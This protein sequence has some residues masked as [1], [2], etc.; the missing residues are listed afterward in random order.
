MLL[1]LAEIS[2][3]TSSTGDR[4]SPRP[5][6]P[7]PVIIHQRPGLPLVGFQTLPDHFLT[8]VIADYQLGAVKIANS[9]D[10]GRLEMD[11]INPSAG[12]TRT[13]SGK[14]EQQLIIVHRQQD[15]NRR[16]TAARNA[17]LSKNSFSRNA[18]SHPAWAAVRGNP[19]RIKPRPQS[20]WS[21]R[22]ATMSQTRSSETSSPRSM[23]ALACT[24]NSV[25]R[26]RSPAADRRWR[27]AGC[28]SA[29]RSA[30]PACLCQ[31]PAVPA[32]P[33]D[34]HSA[35]FLRHGTGPRLLPDPAPTGRQD[36]RSAVTANPRVQ[37][38]KPG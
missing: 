7:A 10:T 35:R 8:I 11:V 38:P 24:P 5:T 9:I 4:H 2:A 26:A 32:K 16:H 22:S 6:V 19:S 14:P 29:R 20:G 34:R 13:T 12:G 33:S 37:L 30:W 18:S 31:R 21:S 1:D 25:L 36:L 17:T 28:R 23:I 27:S 15:H 3:V